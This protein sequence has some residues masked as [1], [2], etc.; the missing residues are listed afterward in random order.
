MVKTQQWSKGK[1]V[2]RVQIGMHGFRDKDILGFRDL[3]FMELGI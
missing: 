2:K 3:G 1:N